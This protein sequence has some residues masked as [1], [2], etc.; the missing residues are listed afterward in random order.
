MNEWA[1]GRVGT[2]EGGRLYIYI[3]KTR[4]K[5]IYIYINYTYKNEGEEKTTIV[6]R[7]TKQV[8]IYIYYIEEYI[9]ACQYN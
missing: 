1:K 7:Y 2:R 5:K 3:H 4:K 8:D 6:D 9:V